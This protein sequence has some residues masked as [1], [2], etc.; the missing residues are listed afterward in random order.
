MPVEGIRHGI[1]FALEG[2]LP[3]VVRK[4]DTSGGKGLVARITGIDRQVLAVEQPV[5]IAVG[6]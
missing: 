5:A 2:P 3:T 4:N 1:G 6:V